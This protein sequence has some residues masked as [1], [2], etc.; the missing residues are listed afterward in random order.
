MAQESWDRL[1]ETVVI[2]NFGIGAVH[3][4]TR[5]LYYFHVS[6]RLEKMKP[7]AYHGAPYLCD[8]RPGVSWWAKFLPFVL[9]FV[10]GYRHVPVF[11]FRKLAFAILSILIPSYS[12]FILGVSSSQTAGEGELC[13]R[14]GYSWRYCEVYYWSEAGFGGADDLIR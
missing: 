11:S 3:L 12:M 10:G 2:I 7:R 14:G 13:W 1:V 4:P 8:T 6:T 9:D 5:A